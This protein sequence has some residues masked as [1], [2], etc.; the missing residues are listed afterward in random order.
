LPRVKVAL[1]ILVLGVVAIVVSNKGLLVAAMADG[2]PF[3]WELNK[4]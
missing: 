4:V 2:S 1:V 3:R